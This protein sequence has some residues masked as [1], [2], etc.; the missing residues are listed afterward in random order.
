[1][2]KWT[3]FKKFASQTKKDIKER[4]EKSAEM[5]NIRSRLPLEEDHIKELKNAGYSFVNSEVVGRGSFGHL[6]SCMCQKQ[7]TNTQPKEMT[8][9]LVQ[10]EQNI[11]YSS[12]FLNDFNSEIRVNERIN[13]PNVNIIHWVY[14]IGDPAA[15]N[16]AKTLIF[17]QRCQGNLSNFS[18]RVFRKEK[19]NEFQAGRVFV[20]IAQ[21]IKYL[22][23]ANKVIEQQNPDGSV[24][25]IVQLIP[26]KIGTITEAKILWR[27]T[28]DT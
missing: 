11:K 25:K 24:S 10:V 23:G 5:R 16:P 3:Q 17:A 19:I 26:I 28:S 22:H 15:R 14:Y 13:H 1:M 21:G 7:G 12:K 27:Q 4:M 6:Y 2:K 9:E 20:Q 8:C 18:L